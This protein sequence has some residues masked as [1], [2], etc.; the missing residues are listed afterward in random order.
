MQLSLA[1]KSGPLQTN[2][3][4]WQ[5]EILKAVAT[6]CNYNYDYE[7]LESTALFYAFFSLFQTNRLT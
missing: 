7:A 1:L 3:A 6:Q 5:R 2:L 4:T